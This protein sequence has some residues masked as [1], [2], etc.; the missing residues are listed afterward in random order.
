MIALPYDY[1]LI[2]WFVLAAGCTAYVAFDQFNGN[3]EPTVMKWGFILV[4]LYM[5]PF[6]LLLYVLADKEPRPGEHEHFTSPLWKQGVGSTIHCVAGDATG[7]ILAATVTA[8]LGLPM[9]IDLIVE[10]VAGFSFGLF[11]FQSLFMKKTMGG[12]YWENVRKSFMPEF[13]SMNAMMAGMAPTMSLLM[14]GRDMRAMDPL[15]LVFWGVMSLGVMVGFATAYPFNVWMVK[16]KIKH[17]LMTERGGSEQRQEGHEG[18]GGGEPPKHDVG[19]MKHGSGHQMGSDATT[20]QLAA[21]AGVTSLLLISGMVIP[22]F[23]VNLGLSARDV[24]GSIMPPGMIN[25]FDLPGEAM[26]DMAAVKPR[27]VAYVAAPNARGDKVLEPR[28]ENG[29]KVFDIK[30]EIIRWNILPDVAVEAYA[31]NR[32]V[33]GPRLQVTE[34][35]H[36]RINFR[37]ALPESSTIHWHGLILPNEMDGPAKVTQDPVPPGGSYTYEFDVGQSGTYFYHSHDHPDRQQAL[38]LYGA[39]L[40]A[41]KDSA[42]EVR[43]DLDYTIQLQEWLKREWLTYPAMLMEGALPNYFTINGKA[44]PSTDTVA[45]KVGQTIKIRFIGTNNN[46]VHPMHV[47]G[48][49]FEVVAVDGVNLKDSARYQADTVNVGPGQRYDVIWTARKPGKWLVHCHIPHHTANNNV[50]QH[51]GGGLMLVLNVQ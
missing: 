30:A 13:I 19:E 27:Q 28:I 31:Y 35:D 8:L 37:N 7:I 20:P 26:K 39:L 12:T 50:E 48:G 49:P 15:E 46:F 43:A 29:V 24:D 3:P 34:G 42:A 9:W 11:I 18:H 2:A 10:Y 23:S 1:F 45:M 38:G 47:H 5:G 36:V 25:T 51:G 41:P 32:Q 22:G 14:M 21:L 16:K 44:Y 33:P 40:I 6:G 17:G 4:T